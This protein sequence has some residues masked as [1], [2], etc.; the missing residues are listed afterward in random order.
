[1]HFLSFYLVASCFMLCALDFPT[2][3]GSTEGMLLLEVDRVLKPGGYFVLTS[4]S[5]KS[6][7]SSVNKKKRT[8]FTPLEMITQEICWSLLAQQDETF[9]WQKTSDVHC[10]SSR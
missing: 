3:T 10:Y 4:P 5:L 6:E 2:M 8:M 1:M 7:G 9:V